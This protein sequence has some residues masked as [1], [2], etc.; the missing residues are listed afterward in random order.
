MQKKGRLTSR[1]K[2]KSKELLGYEMNQEELRLMPYIHYVMVNEHKV[3]PNHIGGGER[4]ILQKWREAGYMEGGASGMTITKEF[5]N[6][7]SEII[8]LGYVDID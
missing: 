7:L 3:N 1:I 6:I 4:E 8:F 2:S 5:W